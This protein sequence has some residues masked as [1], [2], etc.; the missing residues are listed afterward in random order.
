M[1]DI[2][3]VDY[4]VKDKE[5]NTPFFTAVEHGFLH[6]V[7]YF[8]EE[9]KISPHSAKEGNIRALHIAANNNQTEIIEYLINKGCDIEQVSIYGKPINWAVGQRQL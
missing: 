9:L 4:E 3:K 1:I 2:L 6:L 7:K 8:V 5:G